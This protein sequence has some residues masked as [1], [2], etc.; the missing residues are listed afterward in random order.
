M[1]TN[2]TPR[3]ETKRLPREKWQAYFDRFARQY[4]GEDE[5]ET[6]TV[7]VVS[8]T[9]GDQFEVEAVRLLGVSYDP[10]D[11]VFELQLENVDHLVFEPVEIWALEGEGGFLSTLEVVHSDGT[12]E[13]IYLRKSSPLGPRDDASVASP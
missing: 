13:I 5:P 4:L 9:L 7:E 11:N 3:L 2:P 10:K 1:A 6:A 8:P 12:K